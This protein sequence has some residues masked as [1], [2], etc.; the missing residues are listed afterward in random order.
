MFPHQSFC[1]NCSSCLMPE[2][3]VNRTARAPEARTQYEVVPHNNTHRSALWM[4]VC[5]L[6]AECITLPWGCQELLSQMA[7]QTVTLVREQPSSTWRSFPVAERCWWLQ[8]GKGCNRAGGTC[9]IKCPADTACQH[10]E[11]LTK[12][13]CKGVKQSWKNTLTVNFQIHFS[14]IKRFYKGSAWILI[15]CLL[16]TIWAGV[17]DFRRL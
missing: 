1:S 2:G 8:R 3:C 17:S 12:Y 15:T 10:T 11:L 16:K 6:P 5:P 4:F 14:E 9:R 7:Q 13:L